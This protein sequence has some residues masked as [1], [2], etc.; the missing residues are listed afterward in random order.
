MSITALPTPPSRS[1][2]ANFAT[3]GDAF[4]GALPQFATEANALAEEVNANA[5]SASAGAAAASAA[6]GVTIWVSG[7]TYA[8]GDCRFSPSDYQTYRR[9]TAGAGTTDPAADSTN[10]VRLTLDRAWAIKTGAYTAIAGDR[11]FCDTSAAAWTLTLPASPSV[12]AEVAIIDLT[13]SFE[14][15]NL[16]VARNGELIMGL[17]EDMTASTDNATIVLIYSGATYGWRIK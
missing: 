7:T 14:T 11:L 10:W 13:G 9:K 12:G 16:T 8:V 2:S 15:N 3:R 4:L 17:A 5:I 1:D 6:S